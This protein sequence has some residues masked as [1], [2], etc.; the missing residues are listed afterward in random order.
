MCATVEDT[1]EVVIV[2]ATSCAQMYSAY[3]SCVFVAYLFA[4]FSC[5]V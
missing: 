4:Y 5:A 3:S 1:I 2:F